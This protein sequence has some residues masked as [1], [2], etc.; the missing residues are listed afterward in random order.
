MNYFFTQTCL[1][2]DRDAKKSAQGAKEN[3]AT[4]QS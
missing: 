4:L 1:S 3:F 2:A